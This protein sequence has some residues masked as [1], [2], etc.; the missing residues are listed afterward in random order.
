MET[1]RPVSYKL[2]SMFNTPPVLCRLQKV[3]GLKVMKRSNGSLAYTGGC[4]PRS[5]CEEFVGLTLKRLC[6]SNEAAYTICCPDPSCLRRILMVVAGRRQARWMEPVGFNFKHG[7]C[8]MCVVSESYTVKHLYPTI[9]TYRPLP[10]RDRFKWVP[11]D[12]PYY[13]TVMIFYKSPT[14]VFCISTVLFGPKVIFE[15]PKTIDRPS[16][17]T[18]IF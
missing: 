8:T 17:R 13:T 5:E 12:H 11:N 3:C 4:F 9:S 14:S 2:C 16:L 7:T 1:F 10:Y 15:S 6:V 18:I